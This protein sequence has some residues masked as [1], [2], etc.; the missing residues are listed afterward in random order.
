M[1]EDILKQGG[2]KEKV[3]KNEVN[4]DVSKYCHTNIAIIF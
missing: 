4:I 2:I 3:E 1:Q